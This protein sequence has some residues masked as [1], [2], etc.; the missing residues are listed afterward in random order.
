MLYSNPVEICSGKLERVEEKLA[1]VK[2]DGFENGKNRT[3]PR[4]IQR[5]G[6]RKSQN[7]PIKTAFTTLLLLLL[8]SFE[9]CSRQMYLCSLQAFQLRLEL[10]DLRLHLLKSSLRHAAPLLSTSRPGVLKR[11]FKVLQD[12][13]TQRKKHH[14]NDRFNRAGSKTKQ[15]GQQRRK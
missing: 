4:L 2:T 15:E 12:N 7:T 1:E 8:P 9:R 6:H 11:R 5:Y 3:P 10:L 14:E 13:C